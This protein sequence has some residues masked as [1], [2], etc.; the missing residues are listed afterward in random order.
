MKKA[1]GSRIG[2]Y[3]IVG[4]LGAGGMGEVYRA[5]DT[6]LRREVALK[7]LPDAYA[8]DRERRARFEREAQ[9]LAALNHPHIAAI[10]GFEDSSTP[11]LVMELVEGPTLADRITGGPVP[12][13]E[14]IGIARQLALALDAAHERGIVH[15]DLKP[16]NIKLAADG[17]IKVLDFGLAKA[18]TGDGP[19]PSDIAN[20]P[21]VSV[22][23]TAAGVIL[24][25]AAYMSPEQA[26]GQAVDKRTDIWAFGCVLFELLT[27]RRPFD[28]AT[29][30]DVVAA[31]LTRDPPWPALPSDVPDP[32]R[33]LLRRCLEKDPKKRLRDI[34]D[35]SF[36]AP[37]TI[38]HR[39]SRI[40]PLAAAAATAAVLSAVVTAVVSRSRPA[41]DT[42]LR[43]NQT[44]ATRLTEYGGSE[45][46]PAL[47]PDGRAFVFIS[48][49]TGT[50][51]IWLRQ[52][53]GGE[54]V[55][56]TDDA[57]PESELAYA[58]DGESVYFTRSDVDGISIWQTGVLGGRPRRV[59]AGA[60]TACPSPDGR[61][62]AFQMTDGAGANLV[63]RALES[64]ENRV[65]AK[66]LP[67][68]TART[69]WSKDSRFLSYTRGGLFAPSNL[70]VIDMTTGRDRQV[71]NFTRGN[72]GITGHAWLPDNRHLVVS[73]VPFQRQLPAADIGILDIEDG[74]IARMTTTVQHGLITPSV[75]ADG[76]RLIVTSQEFA[77][78]VWRIPA[79]AGETPQRLAGPRGDPMWIFLTRGG[80]TLLYNGT[81][82]GS[83][84]LWIGP[85]ESPVDARQV[86]FVPG[87]AIAHSSLSP[88]GSQ[89]AFVSTATG[90]SDV[91]VQN[92]D[93]T[94][95]RQ[96]TNDPAA[97]SWPVWS[98]DGKSLVYTSLR[99][100]RQE[101]WRVPASG[102]VAE[103]LFD[104][105]FRGDWR[106]QPT[107]SG[108]WIVTSNGQ[109]R[110]RLL[111]VERRTVIWDLRV[112][113]SALSLPMF[114]P[115]GRSFSLPFQAGRDR[116]TIGIFDTA[117]GARQRIIEMPFRVFFRAGWID[118]GSAFIVNRNASTSHIVLFDR[119]WAG[120]DASRASA[121]GG[122]ER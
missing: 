121:T 106:P 20:S 57:A 2:A 102:G 9:I 109:D 4:L 8:L 44:V 107:G 90:N 71:T 85:L 69:A 97:D 76:S 19:A 40:A 13:P 74:S 38:E 105:F 103:K 17:S 119:F 112:P 24:G 42:G 110:V 62:L 113:S 49:H 55:R 94:D 83:R 87:D 114:S 95:L 91:W 26:R 111:D 101:T 50:P 23:G 31:I 33:L 100:S 99:D 88:D 96:L 43:A 34:A 75:S 64:A 72:E 66:S 80:R 12:V 115:D 81:A 30:S 25:T 28:G 84:N 47:S 6:K 93:G 27:G 58:P 5:R 67:G 46:N 1:E 51:D 118:N 18:V 37:I 65:L 116:D 68:G 21:T 104:G 79:S 10:Y 36:D 70:F 59:L 41:A 22:M 78:E 120:G 39:A 56:L 108:T 11:A 61:R 29:A 52:V 60:R 117:S 122:R 63:V 53:A 92:V 54:P 77:R 7:L 82:S 15:R 98:P 48:D 32:I 16:A 3:E 73:Y 86:T 89:V 45:S 14:A 35:A